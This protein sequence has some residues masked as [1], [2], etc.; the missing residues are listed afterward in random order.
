[1]KAQVPVSPAVVEKP[2]VRER[3]EAWTAE[4]ILGK[5]VRSRRFIE[6]AAL[7][8][9]NRQSPAQRDGEDTGVADGMGYSRY[10]KGFMSS[11]CEQMLESTRPEGHRLTD[12]QL[13]AAI[14]V[15][16]RYAKQLAAIANGNEVATAKLEAARAGRR[17]VPAGYCDVCHGTHTIVE[18]FLGEPIVV[19]CPKC[20]DTPYAD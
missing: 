18:N 1:M 12:R 16:R 13:T 19:P 10:D 15:L 14:R 17:F 8:L 2:K 4:E 11:L 20:G 5:M 3:A 6:R 9:Y 7:A